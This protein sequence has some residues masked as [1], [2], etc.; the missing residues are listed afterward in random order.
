MLLLPFLDLC[1]T[2]CLISCLLCVISFRF[3]PFYAYFINFI[4]REDSIFF[5]NNKDF[6]IFFGKK[7]FI[8]S[9]IAHSNLQTGGIFIAKKALRT[10]IAD[11]K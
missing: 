10:D 2:F 9:F 11:I 5:Q 3:L 1:Y 4:L 8:L 7:S 6:Y